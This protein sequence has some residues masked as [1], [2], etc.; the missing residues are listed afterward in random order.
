[1]RHSVWNSSPEAVE[2]DADRSLT[3]DEPQ[4]SN[5]VPAIQPKEPDADA[6]LLRRSEDVHAQ[7]GAPFTVQELQRRDLEIPRGVLGLYDLIEHSTVPTMN[8]R[9]LLSDADM[10]AR[11][12]YGP[13]PHSTLWP[14]PLELS[15]RGNSRVG[16][17]NIPSG[18]IHNMNDQM[19]PN[20]YPR[21]RDVEVDL[22]EGLA[23]RPEFNRRVDEG[24]IDGP[25]EKR[26]DP[27]DTSTRVV[28]DLVARIDQE[29]DHKE[30]PITSQE[31]NARFKADNIPKM[32]SELL[33]STKKQ[34]GLDRILN[35]NV[36]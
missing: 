30:L 31:L 1:M 11:R 5:T 7:H 23:R 36:S 20:S 21:S 22:I 15:H 18:D 8:E 35:S 17:N 10:D 32:I 2:N 25:P 4:S 26:D 34:T 6:N 12:P 3:S 24:V 9:N 14:A 29:Y 19:T 33:N 13:L 27:D 28:N 16:P